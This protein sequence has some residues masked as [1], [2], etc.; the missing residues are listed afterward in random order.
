MVLLTFI[1]QI[2]VL[3]PDAEIVIVAKVEVWWKY[4]VEFEE[5]VDTTAAMRVLEQIIGSE[6]EDNLLYCRA[7]GGTRR[8]DSS[9]IGGVDYLPFDEPQAERESKVKPSCHRSNK[10]LIKSS[11]SLFSLSGES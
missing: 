2:I 9:L 1:L 7:S 4:S 8:L 10:I 11:F 5:S 3:C 6:L